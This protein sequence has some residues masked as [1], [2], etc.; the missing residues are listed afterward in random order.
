MIQQA[1]DIEEREE[2]GYDE[3]EGKGAKFDD[4]DDANAKDID[5]ET[6]DPPGVNYIQDAIEEG[7]RQHYGS[8]WFK[9]GDI[10]LSREEV[11]G[12]E[13]SAATNKRKLWKKYGESHYSDILFSECQVAG[14]LIDLNFKDL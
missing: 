10:L 5:L 12:G 9:E 8:K 14:I 11:E 4:T 2:L 6:Q 7:A 1:P 3:G 13:R